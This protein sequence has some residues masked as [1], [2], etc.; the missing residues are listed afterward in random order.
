MKFHCL[1]A[2]SIL[3]W[4]IVMT[5][6]F[7]RSKNGITYG[8]LPQ[9]TTPMFRRS[10]D[11]MTYGGYHAVRFGDY[12]FTYCEARWLSYIYD[13]QFYYKPFDYG[14]YL[15]A[16]IAH[17]HVNESGKREMLIGSPIQINSDN[18]DVLYVTNDF[19]TTDFQVDWTDSGFLKLIRSEI[20]LIDPS[21][22]EKIAIPQDH[23]SVAM[24]VRRGGGAD[25]KL[26]QDDIAL[27]VEG[28]GSDW[29]P[30]FYADK[31]WP[32]RF[33]PDSYYIEQLKVLAEL[34]PDKKLYVHIFTDDPAP[35]NIAAKYKAALDNPRIQFGYRAE[36]NTHNSNVLADFFAIMDFDAL[37]RS[38]SHFA[39][40]A[41]AIG[42][43]NYEVGPAA[44]R[45][46]GR[47]LIITEVT[48]VERR[49][50]YATSSFIPWSR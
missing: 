27:G 38:A 31:E 34:H 8:G 44:Y 7:T 11:G 2:Y 32:M 22:K 15:V 49:G 6:T 35:E 37:I 30:N 41:G 21:I 10:Q 19:Y 26:Y 36:S 20:A 40:M 42:G 47:K 46:E 45:W 33:A 29:D 17:K 12:I 14:N 9:R 5:S 13:L 16:S 23:Y 28:W 24:H 4:G 1:I 18:S 3:L 50:D 48:F 43:V 25:A 39:I